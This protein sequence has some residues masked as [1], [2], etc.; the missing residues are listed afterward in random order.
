MAVMDMMHVY[1][2]KFPQQRAS[3][4]R[5]IYYAPVLFGLIVQG[6]LP[7]LVRRGE[8]RRRR[9]VWLVRTLNAH[10]HLVDVAQRFKVRLPGERLVLCREPRG[11]D[12]AR[13]VFGAGPDGAPRAL[14]PVRR[15]DAD[16]PRVSLAT[17]VVAAGR[18]KRNAILKR[19]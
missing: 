14:G 11:A 19:V 18:G 8:K 17:P 2:L 9:H 10:K 7:A 3:V 12:V 1:G 6:P 5:A 4:S 15:R 13:V 16:Q